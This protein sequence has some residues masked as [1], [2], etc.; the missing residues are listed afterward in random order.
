MISISSFISIIIYHNTY[1]SNNKRQIL[2]TLLL[3]LRLMR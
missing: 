3:P 1:T 2:M